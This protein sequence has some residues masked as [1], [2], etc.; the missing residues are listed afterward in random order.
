MIRVLY[1]GH[2]GTYRDAEGNVI[3]DDPNVPAI[4]ENL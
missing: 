2:D 4:P 1:Q 3:A